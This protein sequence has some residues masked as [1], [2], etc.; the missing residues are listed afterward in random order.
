MQ[1]RSPTLALTCC[2]KRGRSERWR[3][4]GAV[5]DGVKTLLLWAVQTHGPPQ[6]ASLY[7]SPSLLSGQ[8]V[9]WTSASAALPTTRHTQPRAAISPGLPTILSPRRRG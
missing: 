4:S 8:I 5:R 9:S 7:A 1:M 2:R 3:Q 6:N